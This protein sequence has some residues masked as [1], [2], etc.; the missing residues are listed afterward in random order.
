VS[1]NTAL[2]PETEVRRREKISRSLMGNHNGAFKR[3]AVH[4]AANSV[5]QRRRYQD[6][7]EHEKTSRAMKGKGGPRSHRVGC[8][9]GWH[10]CNRIK[11]VHDG[12]PSPGPGWKTARKVVWARDKVCRVCGGSPSKK[13]RLDV[14]HI[15]PRRDGGTNDLENLLGMHHGCHMK[16]ETGKLPCPPPQPIMTTPSR[17]GRGLGR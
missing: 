6:P 11:S 10:N 7:A 1:Y 9:C 16:V 4:N 17:N 13:R 8:S 12:P 2:Y 3:T 5:G 14:H 15:V